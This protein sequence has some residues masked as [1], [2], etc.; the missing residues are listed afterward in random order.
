MSGRSRHDGRTNDLRKVHPRRH[1]STALTNVR[2]SRRRRRE[3]HR[4]RQGSRSVRRRPLWR[5]TSRRG[6]S[7]HSHRLQR[8]G[9]QDA[10]LMKAFTRSLL[11]VTMSNNRVVPMM[12]ERRRGACRRMTRSGTSTRLRV[13]RVD[14]RRR[15]QRARRNSTQGENARRSRDRRVP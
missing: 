8:R 10:H 6:T 3:C 4:P 5:G 14:L 2:P 12:S 15:A 9:R 1:L 11:R 7:Y 13:N